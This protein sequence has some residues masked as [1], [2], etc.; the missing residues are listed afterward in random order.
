MF[1][2]I[3]GTVV[4]ILETSIVID[5]NGIGYE[6][7]TPIPMEF[8]VGSIDTIYT[9]NHVREDIFALFGFKSLEILEFFKKIITVKGVGPKTGLAILKNTNLH[10]M[11]EA[12]ES[13]DVSYLRTL[14]GIGPKMASQMV[15]DLKGKL[16]ITQA[17]SPNLQAV[18]DVFVSLMNL[19]FKQKELD[20]IKERLLTLD[21]SDV[22]TL[23]RSA[24]QYLAK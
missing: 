21:T 6:I 23:L 20:A 5:N 18:E 2:Y 10:Q 24:L 14:P 3:K 13:S 16:V 12:I 7:F 1:A 19:G 8:E 15:L 22:D 4:M 17:Y 9:Y 11:V